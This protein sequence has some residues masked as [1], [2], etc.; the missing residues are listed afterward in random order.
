MRPVPESL[1]T[2]RLLL[3]RWRPEDREPF[4]RLSMDAHVM[5]FF[6]RPRTREEALGTLDRTAENFARRGFGLWAVEAPGIAPFLGIAGVFKHRTEPPFGDCLEIGWRF[7]QPFWGFG[8][9]PEAARAVVRDLF[10]REAH[11]RLAA[12]TSH[13][14]LPSRRVMEK[15]GMTHDPADD[16]EEA[17]IPVGNP[18]RAQV[19]YRLDR[20]RFAAAG[21]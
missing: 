18:A 9:A 17:D 13:D 3:R 10:A 6:D 12:C 20:A 11:E 16:F 5:R 4:A 14:N 15:L 7:D 21:G 2:E 8:Y 19:L 1:R